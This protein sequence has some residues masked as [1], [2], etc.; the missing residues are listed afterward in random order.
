MAVLVAVRHIALGQRIQVVL[1][2][3]VKAILADQ[4]V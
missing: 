2:R 1:V 4:T 3:L